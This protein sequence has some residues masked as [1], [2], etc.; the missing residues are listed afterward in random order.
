[1][2]SPAP[3]AAS[4]PEPTP[5]QL[6]TDRRSRHH[7]SGNAATNAAAQPG[8]GST[9]LSTTASNGS[10]NRPGTCGVSSTKNTQHCSSLTTGDLRHPQDGRLRAE[11][12]QPL[13][14]PRPVA[15]LVREP[16]VPG[17]GPRS[18]PPGVRLRAAARCPLGRRRRQRL[19]R[20]R[21]Q[22]RAERIT[23]ANAGW[24]GKRTAKGDIFRVG[25]RRPAGVMVKTCKQADHHDQQQ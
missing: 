21:A 12:R 16:A 9:P 24:G 19:D 4:V 10:V 20:P 5:F 25:C 22:P 8:S 23:V 1:M 6:A 13:V 7:R 3:S 11:D 15:L 2:R 17:A 14:L 18:R